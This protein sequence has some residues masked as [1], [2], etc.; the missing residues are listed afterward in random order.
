VFI[1]G[2]ATP[3]PGFQRTRMLEAIGRFASSLNKRVCF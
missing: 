1:N 2:V 3:L